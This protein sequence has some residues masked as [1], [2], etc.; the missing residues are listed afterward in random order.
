MPLPPNK[1]HRLA[2][3]VNKLDYSTSWLDVMYQPFH[4]PS[5]IRK[6]DPPTTADQATF[7]LPFSTSDDESAPEA[8]SVSARQQLRSLRSQLTALPQRH[9]DK[10]H[11]GRYSAMTTSWHRRPLCARLLY[12][13][14]SERLRSFAT[15]YAAFPPRKLA[16][17]PTCSLLQFSAVCCTLPCRFAPTSDLL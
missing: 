13:P 8:K 16:S 10:L 1:T 14:K 12:A 17:L 3:T 6:F 2:Y 11:H 7:V 15:A 5:T 9:S 4:Q